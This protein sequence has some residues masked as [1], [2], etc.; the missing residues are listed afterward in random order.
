MLPLD[1]A[2]SGS[3]RQLVDSPGSVLL[4]RLDAFV[5]DAGEEQR[6]AW[7]SEVAVLVEQGATVI[8]LDPPA[9]KHSAVLEYLLPREGGRRPDV[10]VLQNSRVVVIEFK[11]TGQLHRSDADQVRAYARDLR[12]YHSA[13]HGVEVTPVLVLSGVGAVAA[14]AFGVFVVPANELATTLVRLGRTSAS[15]APNLVSFLDGEYAPMPTLVAAARTLFENLP[16][17][18]IR[19]AQSAGV[20]DAVTRILALAKEVRERR[21]RHLV[22]L[23]GVPGAGKTLVGLQVA[24]S[25]ALEEGYRFGVRANRGSPATFLSGNGPLVQVLQHALKSGVFVQ[26]MHRFIHEYGLIHPERVPHERL[27]VFDEAQRAWDAAKMEDFYSR[28]IAAGTVNLRRSEP[29]LLVEIADRISEGALVLGLVG[30]GQEIH[31]G[32]EGGIAGWAAAVARS[33]AAWTVHGPPS[34][35]THFGRVGVRFVDEPLLDLNTSLRAQSAEHVHEWV[36]LVLDDGDLERA[37]PLANSLHYAGF[38]IYVTRDLGGARQYAIDRFVGEPDRRVG[39]LTSSKARNLSPYGL[40]AD[41]QATKRIRIGPWFNDDG[42]SIRSGS[43]MDSVITEF[44]CQGL[45]LDLPVVC[46]GDDFWWEGGGWRMRPVRN[47]PLVRDAAALRRNA[48]RV[49]LT[50]GREGVL[51]FVPPTPAMEMNA[52]FDALRRAGAIEA[53]G[54]RVVAA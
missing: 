35:R 34:Q 41:F 36:R 16:L 40:D 28:K 33:P 12:E 11:S 43:R 5:P 18:H 25:A 2:W 24:H 23:T 29:D 38:P 8:A 51:V 7:K 54:A 53:R 22:L 13:C 9:A 49:L 17:P 44:Q 19:R 47:N 46:W 15:P 4:A 26:D 31:T 10:L 30:Q 52:T 1:H 6:A 39:L 48:Y 3:L 45:E 50:R 42:R 37:S 20:N 27:I 14:E 21:E 32:E